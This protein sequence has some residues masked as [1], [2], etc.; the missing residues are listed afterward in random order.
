MKDPWCNA[1]FELIWYSEFILAHDALKARFSKVRDLY[2]AKIIN[3]KYLFD[4]FWHLKNIKNK[5]PHNPMEIFRLYKRRQGHDDDVY[6]VQKNQDGRQSYT[7]Q[8]L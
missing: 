6:D 8:V 1:I 3:G 4:S 5:T 7:Y 2:L